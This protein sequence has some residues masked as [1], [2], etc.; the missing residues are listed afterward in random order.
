MSPPY[1]ELDIEKLRRHVPQ[2]LRRQHVWL[3]WKAVPDADAAKKPKKVP[4]YGSGKRRGGRL[5]TPGDRA[6][7]ETFDDIVHFFNP[8]KYAGIGAALGPLSDGCILSGIDLDGSVLGERTLSAEAQ[9]IIAAANGSY[10]EFSPSLTGIKL[11]GRG[12]IGTLREARVEIYSAKRFF[13]VTGE[14]I[15]GDKLG[16]L[17]EAARLARQLFR[18][19]S[20]TASSLVGEGGRN[21]RV[22]S[23][24]ILL[25]RRGVPLDEATRILARFNAQCCIPP[26]PDDEVRQIIRG[27]WKYTIGF[28][29]TDTGN[30]ERFVT[31]RG[32]DYRY[33]VGAGWATFESHR[34][35]IDLGEHRARVAMI[36]VARD[37]Q[38][39]AAPLPE[40]QRSKLIK[41]GLATEAKSRLDAALDIAK[42][43]P[44]VLDKLENYDANPHLIGFPNGVY[45][46]EADRLR[47][48]LPQDRLTL[49]MGTRF[50]SS[51]TAPRWEQFQREVHGDN[52]DI[53]AFKRRAWGYTLSGLTT[54]QKLFMAYG[55][56]A[57]GKS[58][59]LTT[60][61]TL[62]GDY[63]RK[64]EPE[65]LLVRSKRDSSND[66]ARLRGARFTPTVEVED[67]RAMAE[68][69]VKQLT[70]GDK[71][72]ARFLYQEFVDF[73]PVCKIWIAT[74]HRPEIRGTDH[75]IWRRIVLIPYEVQFDDS[76]RD[77]DLAAKLIAEGPGIINWAIEGFR[78]W[79]RDG[80]QV[81]KEVQEATSAYREDMDRI[82]HFLDEC[83]KHGPDIKGRTKATDLYSAY[84]RWCRDSNTLPLNARRFYERLER[85][86]RLHRVDGDSGRRSVVVGVLLLD[87][88]GWHDRLEF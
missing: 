44:V 13:T 52:Q 86:H 55:E 49:Q 15:S 54:E 16:D 51:A 85:D 26:L 47:D 19:T 37:M 1:N 58:T 83:T 50:D 48:G 39:E 77:P 73:F 76:Q 56:G 62:M 43:H 28:P 20:A 35:N 41:H 36:S 34:W 53:I 70:G 18:A 6:G 17:T 75:A 60:M 30:A 67:G 9:Q 7:L 5:D 65:T 71:I 25:R 61:L 40:E 64:I 29:N 63:G 87:T 24:A 10:V 3:Y 84:G 42:S 32:G 80:L 21:N 57:N 66:V 4:Y 46:L 11:F 23:Y 38:V 79:R 31:A 2:E 33:L 81:P 14:R 74:N 88:G 8:S 72:S 45:D 22:F 27:A 68:S 82:K 78:E 69:L 12:D 59:E